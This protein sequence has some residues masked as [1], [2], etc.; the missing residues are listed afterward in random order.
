MKGSKFKR[1]YLLF[2]SKR[3]KR[4]LEGK[5][6]GRQWSP[7]PSSSLALTTAKASALGALVDSSGR[8]RR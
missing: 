2:E 1:K 7:L 6:C 8:H 5:G 4:A 3:K